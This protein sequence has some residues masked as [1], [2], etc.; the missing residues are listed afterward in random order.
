M[1]EKLRAS[2][3]ARIVIFVLFMVLATILKNGIFNNIAWIGYGASLIL[4]PC[5]PKAW[6]YADH[7]KLTLG[8]RIAGVIAI[9]VGLITRFGV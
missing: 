9:V 3:A 1:L 8:C 5:W 4:F 2:F 7:K 6:D